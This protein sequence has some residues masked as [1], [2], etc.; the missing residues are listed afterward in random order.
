MMDWN[1]NLA[2]VRHSFTSP[3]RKGVHARL[4]RA[5]AFALMCFLVERTTTECNDPPA[6][7]ADR[8]HHSV[9]KTIV[10]YRDIVGRHQKAGLDHVLDRHAEAAEVLLEG[11]T[12]GRS[13]TDAES[14]LGDRIKAA[15]GQIAAR[16][17]AGPAGQRRLEKF[18]SKRNHFVE[19]AP[20]PLLG[21]GLTG[22]FRH[23]QTGK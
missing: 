16:P 9:A 10:R 13:V 11:E 4:R 18:S 7:I 1:A 17:S 3:Q 14:E 6:K 21:L 5:S 23:R 20:T 19:S 15:V 2:R 22:H 8:E 12:L